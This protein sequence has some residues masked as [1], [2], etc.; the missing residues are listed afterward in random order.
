MCSIGWVVVFQFVMMVSHAMVQY[1]IQCLDKVWYR[2]YSIEGL[3]SGGE[4]VLKI[5][6]YDL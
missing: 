3:V 5:L 1:V 4:W 6:A 2:N